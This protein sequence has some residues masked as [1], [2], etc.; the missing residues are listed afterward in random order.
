LPKLSLVFYRQL[1]AFA[2]LILFLAQTMSRY[3][4]IADYY[5]NTAS[6]ARLCINRDKP[7]MHCN[8]RCQ[9][10]KKLAQQE[11]SDKQN[12][13]KRSGGDKNDPLFSQL[14]YAD[15]SQPFCPDLNQPGF[16]KYLPGATTKT[17]RS[18]FHPPDHRQV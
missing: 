17:P 9:L 18:Y 15:F 5:L 13:E 8:G 4:T 11:N 16:V 14:A 7:V 1:T 12:Q 10:S 6:Y 3:I 2:L